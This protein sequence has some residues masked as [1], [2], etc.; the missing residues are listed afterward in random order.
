MRRVLSD[1][2][3]RAHSAPYDDDIRQRQV[4]EDSRRRHQ[5]R[6]GTKDRTGRGP[7]NRHGY[8][9]KVLSDENGIPGRS[10]AESDSSDESDD[11]SS[12]E[13]DARK[14][15]KKAEREKKAKKAAKKEKRKKGWKK[16][17]LSRMLFGAHGK[18]EGRSSYADQAGYDSGQSDEDWSDDSQGAATSTP[19]TRPD[20][21]NIKLGTTG[22]AGKSQPR[23]KK[24]RS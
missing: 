6:T 15:E 10:S 11:S 20:G 14:K 23:G 8:P 16:K 9:Q 5:V 12:D 24:I 1:E 22:K 13:R 21:G 4:T 18:A 3:L 19:G 2:S 7:Y 17:F